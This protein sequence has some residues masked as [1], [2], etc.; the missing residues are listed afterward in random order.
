MLGLLCYFYHLLPP[1]AIVRV[2]VMCVTRDPTVEARCNRLS[3]CRY[4]RQLLSGPILKDAGSILWLRVL[5]RHNLLVSIPIFLYKIL[6]SHIMSTIHC[7]IHPIVGLRSYTQT[8]ELFP[9]NIASAYWQAGVIFFNSNQV[10][11]QLP[12]QPKTPKPSWMQSCP[13][14]FEMSSQ[15]IK[16]PTSIQQV[17]LDLLKIRQDNNAQYLLQST[18]SRVCIDKVGRAAGAAMA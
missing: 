6:S 9:I 4:W 11:R 18:P 17:K 1:L 15:L 3:S 5:N 12:S 7:G 13:P 10:L 2:G 14:H 16:T 8:C